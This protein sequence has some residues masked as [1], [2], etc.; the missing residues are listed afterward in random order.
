M[1]DI[2]TTVDLKK[3]IDHHYFGDR[4]HIRGRRVPIGQIAAYY[5][6]SHL[7][8]AQIAYELTLS[9][10][11]VLAALLFYQEH[12]ATVEAV[13]AAEQAAKDEMMR[14]HGSSA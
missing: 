2:P 13:E 7:S 10:A 11:Q 5:Y 6:E 3:Y 1:A 9:E 4:P 8:V 12:K 14:R